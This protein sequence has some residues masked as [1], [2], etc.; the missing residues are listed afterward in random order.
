MDLCQAGE[1]SFPATWWEGGWVPEARSCEMTVLPHQLGRR[2]ES[3]FPR[4]EVK[5]PAPPKDFDFEKSDLEKE[6]ERLGMQRLPQSA[7]R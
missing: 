3:T 5:S 1:H 6:G 2:M 4:A 7:S